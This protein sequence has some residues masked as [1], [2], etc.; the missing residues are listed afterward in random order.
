MDPMTMMA[1]A[2]LGGALGGKGSSQKQTQQTTVNNTVGVSSPVSATFGLSVGGNM[3][4][5]LTPSF[6]APITSSANPSMNANDTAAGGTP[7]YLPRVSPTGVVGT[8]AG[9]APARPVSQMDDL[10]LLLMLGGGAYLLL[11]QE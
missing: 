5:T 2:G 11:S 3:P 1:L 7:G 4:Q 9:F 6:N 8:G 10:L